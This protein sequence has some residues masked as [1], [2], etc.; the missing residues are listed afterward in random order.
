ME[1]DLNVRQA[2]RSDLREI[3]LIEVNSFPYPYPIEAFL[4]FLIL[5]PQY[6]LVAEHNNSIVGYVIGSIDSDGTGHI[7]SLAVHPSY[8]GKGIG[9]KL[10]LTVEKIMK[11]NGVHRIKLE[12]SINN[13]AALA[14]YKS[15]G[16]KVVGMERSYYPDGS[17]AYVMFKELSN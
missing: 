3:Y 7:I 9:K 13:K 11:E 4:T 15:V 5:Y 10:L 16:Y 17:D 1:D 6:F 8:R 2:R 14:L 12:V